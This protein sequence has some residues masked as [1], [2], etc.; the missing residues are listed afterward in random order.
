MLNPDLKKSQL[1][2]NNSGQLARFVIVGLV[3]NIAGYFLYLTV[4]WLGAT[5]KI[6]VTFLYPIG[7]AMGFWGNRHIAFNHQGHLLGAGLRYLL[8]HSIGYLMNWSILH[9]FVY[10]NAYPHQLVQGLAVPIVAV[11]L[12]LISKYWVFAPHEKRTVAAP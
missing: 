3:S 7:A 12:F 8:A 10:Q 4:T 2:D 5:P 1:R 11:Y 9:L 6:A